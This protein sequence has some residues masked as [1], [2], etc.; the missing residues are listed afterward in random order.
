MNTNLAEAEEHRTLPYLEALERGPF[1]PVGY[2][3]S[4][5]LS[6]LVAKGLAR[7][8]L[9]FYELTPLGREV[10][11]ALRSKKSCSPT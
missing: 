4:S 5:I 1:S 2:L 9:G 8:R 3:Y 6:D 11:E 7:L 10:L